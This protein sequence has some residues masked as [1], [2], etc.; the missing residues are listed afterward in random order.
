[1]IRVKKKEDNVW[2]MERSK[3]RSYIKWVFKNYQ[4]KKGVL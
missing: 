4:N 1:M 2:K 3:Y